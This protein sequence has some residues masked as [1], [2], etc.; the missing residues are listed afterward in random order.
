VGKGRHRRRFLTQ[1]GEQVCGIELP[2]LQSLPDAA[3]QYAEVEPCEQPNE[4]V[5]ELARPLE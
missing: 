1:G 2:N 3:S 5:I 4:S